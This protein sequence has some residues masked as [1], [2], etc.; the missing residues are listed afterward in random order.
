MLHTGLLAEQVALERQQ[1]RQGLDKLRDNTRRLQDKEY[2]SASVYGVHSIDQLMPLVIERIKDTNN[3]IHEGKTG[4]AFAEIRQFLTDVEPEVAAAIG[5]KV[6]FDKVF[7]SKLR[8]TSFR[9]S[10][11]P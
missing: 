3:R 10:P 5:C 2:A 6:T 9:T 11:T 7:S 1:I 4:Q 8:A